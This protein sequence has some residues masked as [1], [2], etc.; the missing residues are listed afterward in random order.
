MKNSIYFVFFILILSQ[1]TFSQEPIKRR[2]K[3][4]LVLSGGGAKGFAHIGVLKV[5]EQAGCWRIICFGLQ[6]H[7]NRFYFQRH[8]F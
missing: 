6:C 8:Q 5:L 3:I 1:S 4:G 7:S 2:Q